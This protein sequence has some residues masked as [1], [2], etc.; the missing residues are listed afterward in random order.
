MEA[1]DIIGIVL[2]VLE[3]AGAFVNLISNVFDCLTKIMAKKDNSQKVG[4]GTT[5]VFVH[6]SS[7]HW[8]IE[9]MREIHNQRAIEE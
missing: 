9:V 1:I 2:G 5:G 8:Q 4:Q 7:K 3:V 6:K